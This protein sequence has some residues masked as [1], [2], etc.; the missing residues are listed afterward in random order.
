MT[1]TE[2]F[3]AFFKPIAQATPNVKYVM[4]SDADNMDRWLSDSR[5]EDTYPGVFVLRP[6]YKGSYDATMV[7]YFDVIFYV[8]TRGD[9]DSYEHQDEAF[10][11]SEAIATHI[12][13]QIQHIGFNYGC[14]YSFENTVVEPIIYRQHDAAWGYE[15]KLKIGLQANEIFC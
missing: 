12:L 3:W 2:K 8:L 14:F 11:I 5:S 9:L 10:T 4:L 13:Q 7:T 6:R 15:I 1:A